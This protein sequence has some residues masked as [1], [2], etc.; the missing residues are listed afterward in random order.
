ML[1]PV[2]RRKAL[3]FVGSLLL[4]CGGNIAVSGQPGGGDAAAPDGMGSSSGS[5]SGS[6]GSTGGSSGGSSGADSPSCAQ[7][8][9]LCGGACVDEQTDSNNCGGCGLACATGCTAGRC[10]ITLASL[11]SSNQPDHLAV[12]STGVYWTGLDG[13]V[14]SV[15]LEGGAAVTLASGQNGPMGIAVDGTSVYWVDFGGGGNARGSTL[16]VPLAGG[17]PT[18]LASGQSFPGGIAVDA[19]GVYW[20]NGGGLDLDGGTLIAPNTGTVMKAPLGGGA[21][22]TLAS[23]LN[24]PGNIAVDATNVYRTN[25]GSQSGG[26]WANDGSVMK[27]PLTAG[28]A[29]TLAAQGVPFGIAVDAASVYWVDL[30]GTVMKAPLSGGTPTTLAS[31][32][33]P[34]HIAIDATS[35]YWTNVVQASVMKLT[36]K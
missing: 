35:V 1:L 20:V 33:S 15:P 26:T 36:P 23:G 13:T 21:A 14:M 4:G 17:T 32:Q 10:L 22:I 27:L 19:T 6:G 24:V 30:A 28:A 8:E 18:T 9:S 3:L 29:T 25:V 11:S 12:G 34:T 16:K 2:R 7:G 31:N 5:S